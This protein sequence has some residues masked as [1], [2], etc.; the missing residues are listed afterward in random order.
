MLKLNI[1]K[2][3]KIMFTDEELKHILKALKHLYKNTISS[4][5]QKKIRLSIINK[6]ENSTDFTSF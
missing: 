5:N 3:I 6:I 1:T 4:K 2:L